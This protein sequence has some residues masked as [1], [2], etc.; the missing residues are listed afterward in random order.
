MPV[1][2]WKQIK[3]SRLNEDALR[4]QLLNLT[5]DV[6]R[7]IKKDFEKTTATW[8]NKPEFTITRSVSRKRGPEVLV[9]TDD[10]IYKFVDEGTRVRHAVMTTPFVSKTVPNVIGSRRGVGGRL[11][12]SRRIQRPGIKARNFTKI[13][14]KKWQP[15]FKRRGEKAMKRARQISGHAI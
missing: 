12:V 5:R 10:E 3:P 6:G 7:G 14:Q 9:G 15:I 13:L 8:D 4:L 1:V 11:F 2:V